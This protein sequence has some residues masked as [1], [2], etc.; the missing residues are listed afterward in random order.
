[1]LQEKELYKE[2]KKEM[3]DL[4]EAIKIAEDRAKK[5]IEEKDQLTEEV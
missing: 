3:A 1:M 2:T 4:T 5:A